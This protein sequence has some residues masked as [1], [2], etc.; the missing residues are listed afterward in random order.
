MHWIT[1]CAGAAAISGLTL[2]AVPV[3][4]FAA[5]SLL[6]GLRGLGLDLTD[7]TYLYTPDGTSANLAVFSHMVL[8]ALIM[9]LAPLQ[10]IAS[11][12]ARFPAAHRVLGRV[13]VTASIVTALG[14][15]GYIALRG[16]LAGPLMDAGFALYGVLVLVAAI[17]AWRHARAGAYARHRAWA[18]RLLVLV[19]GSL[20]YRLH[21]ALWY[22]LTDGLGSTAQLDGPFDQVQYVAFYLPY[23]LALELWL[24]RSAPAPHAAR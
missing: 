10:L 2:L 11:L 1:G 12:R 20:I 23:L 14:G 15:L 17:Q 22:L 3:L 9:V 5:Y 19:M 18:L 7:E 24:R 6:F 4:A 16:S 13:V 21:Y 8:G